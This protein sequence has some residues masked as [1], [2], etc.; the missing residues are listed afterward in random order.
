LQI[1]K[2]LKKTNLKC[3]KRNLNKK[4]FKNVYY[5]YTPTQ[6]FGYTPARHYRPNV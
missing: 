4:S 3:K 2:T 1:K 5:I 6:I